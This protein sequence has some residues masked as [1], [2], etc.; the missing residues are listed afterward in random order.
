MIVHCI[1][2]KFVT[3]T[4]HLG[5]NEI[6]SSSRLGPLP[7]QIKGLSQLVLALLPCPS[8]IPILPGRCV[9]LL[10]LILTEE[11]HLYPYSQEMATYP[12]PRAY[13]HHTQRSYDTLVNVYVKVSKGNPVW[14]RRTSS[15]HV[16]AERQR[17]RRLLRERPLDVIV[18]DQ[19][20]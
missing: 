4:Q 2:T 12:L 11:E 10:L 20:T 7:S 16:V 6:F 9:S 18:V 1:T 3:L 5:R 14:R 15:S 19:D 13:R 8:C 17:I